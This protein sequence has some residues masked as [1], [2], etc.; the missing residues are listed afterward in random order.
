MIR[1][2]N[3]ESSI[4]KRRSQGRRWAQA[5]SCEYH[6]EVC[7]ADA[8]AMGASKD[9]RRRERSKGDPA[10]LR[11]VVT[12]DIP[13]SEKELIARAIKNA[14][15]RHSAPRKARWRIVKG[16]FSTGQHVSRAI[17]TRYGFDPDQEIGALEQLS[18]EDYEKNLLQNSFF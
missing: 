13:Y 2:G 4:E 18:E 8:R 14:K 17:C 6:H 3:F 10:R 7:E 12:M 11:P 5:D 9:D 15:P 16:L 1:R